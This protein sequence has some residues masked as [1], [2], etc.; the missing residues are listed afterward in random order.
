MERFMSPCGSSPRPVLLAAARFFK[1]GRRHLPRV[2]APKI[3]AIFWT[4][5]AAATGGQEVAGRRC[6]VGF[7]P[8]FAAPSLQAWSRGLQVVLVP[9]CL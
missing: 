2:L 5:Q 1:P 6:G 8:V 7:L 9:L 4:Q 3:S